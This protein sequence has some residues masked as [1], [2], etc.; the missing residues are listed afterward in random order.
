MCLPSA[1][2]PSSE[3]RYQLRPIVTPVPPS[4]GGAA[5]GRRSPSFMKSPTVAVSDPRA[6]ENREVDDEQHDH[7]IVEQRIAGTSGR[8]LRDPQSATALSRIE[9]V[10][11]S[12]R[13]AGKWSSS[14]CCDG[15]QMSLVGREHR[16]IAGHLEPPSAFS[17]HVTGAG[18]GWP[19]LR[20]RLLGPAEN[21]VLSVVRLKPRL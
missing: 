9:R 14:E 11:S 18:P 21:G 13:G 16:V 20:Q 3:A 15:G 7:D 2:C 5:R 19:S 17:T 4:R 10:R 1:L 6:D 12:R 8:D